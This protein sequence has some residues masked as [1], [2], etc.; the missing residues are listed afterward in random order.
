MVI[1]GI[2]VAATRQSSKLQSSDRPRYIAPYAYVAQ[3]TERRTR[4]AK[5]ASSS[6]AVSSTGKFAFPKNLVYNIYTKLKRRYVKY[7]C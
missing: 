7:V 4:K 6:L 3:L 5:V 1:C 2:G